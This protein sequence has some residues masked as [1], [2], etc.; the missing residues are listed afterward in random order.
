MVQ[1]CQ[2][3]QERKCQYKYSFLANNHNF[4]R[5]GG[6]NV[7]VGNSLKTNF[8]FWSAGNESKSLADCRK[9]QNV[10]W[11]SQAVH[12]SGKV[13]SYRLSKTHHPLTWQ[14]IRS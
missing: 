10:C 3:S 7:D 1:V 13:A 12:I 2:T 9:T 11:N 14:Q 4:L 6:N 8:I 5:R